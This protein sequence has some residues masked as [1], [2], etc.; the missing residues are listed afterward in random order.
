MLPGVTEPQ[1]KPEGTVSDIVMVPAKP[2]TAVKVIVELEVDPGAT[3]LGEVALTRK[4]WNLNIA[5]AV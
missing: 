4:S 3:V 1:V 5:E 2:F